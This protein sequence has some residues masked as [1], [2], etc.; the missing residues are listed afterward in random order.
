MDM[1][2]WL[3]L[4]IERGYCSEPVCHTHDGLPYTEEE[5]TEWE[6]GFDPCLHA[7]RLHE[8]A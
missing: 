7:V 6:V 1:A 4:G 5:E 3:R 8:Q 2:E